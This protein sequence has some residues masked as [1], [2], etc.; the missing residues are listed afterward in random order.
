[1]RARSAASLAA[2]TG[3]G[4]AARLAGAPDPTAVLLFGARGLGRFR[5]G[6][7]GPEPPSGLLRDSGLVV[8]RRGG[9]RATLDAG[10]LGYLAIAAHGH[11]D[12]LQVTFARGGLEL[13]TDPG[14]GSY[15]GDPE[16]RRA[17]RGTAFHATVA[18]TAPTRP[19]RPARSSGCATTAPR[20]GT[21]ISPPGSPSRSTTATHA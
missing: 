21:S 12:A 11:A 2:A 20:F 7:P 18:S 8:L 15:Y 13:V 14:A 17:F 10:P 1:M 6:P 4:A 9:T 5:A 3:S 19:G 16:R